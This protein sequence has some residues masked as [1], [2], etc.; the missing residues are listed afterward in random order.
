MKSDTVDLTKVIDAF[1]GLSQE[2]SRLGRRTG[3]LPRRLSLRP[4]WSRQRPRRKPPGS[5]RRHPPLDRLSR[6]DSA[7]SS[8]S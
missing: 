5:P 3:R 6:R 4:Q 1:E 2:L 8:F 7:K